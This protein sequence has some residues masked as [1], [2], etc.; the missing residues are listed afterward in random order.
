MTNVKFS[1]KEFEKQ[2]KLTPEV[3]QK[4]SLFGTPLESISDEEIEIEVFPNRPDLISLQGF[5]RGFKAFI[6]KESGMKKYSL[7]KP[8][9][10]Y[11]VKVSKSVSKVRPY[12]VCAVAS[13]LTLD[14]EKI[15]QLV[16]LQE[17]LHTTIGRNRKKVAIGIY[18]LEK[19]SFPIKYEAREPGKISFIPLEYDKEMSATQILNKHPKGKEFANLLKKEEVFPIFIDAKNK[20][21][22]MPPIINS[23]ETGRVTEKT[24]EV[25]IEC[26]GSNFQTLSKTLNI[27]ITTLIEM[28]AQVYQVNLEYPDKKI[29]S[30]D[31]SSEK[32]KISIENANKLLGLSL[33]EKEIEKLFQKMGCDYNNKVVSIP[34]W[35]T[36]ILHEVDLIEDLAIAYGYDKLIPEIPKVSTIAEESPKEK[37]K[38]KVSEILVGLGLTEI[39]SY[40]LI[41]ENEAAISGLKE[42]IELQ[43]SKTEYKILRPNLLIPALRIFS[44]N[45]DNEYPQEIFEIGTVFSLDKDDETETGIKEKENLLVAFSPGNFTK[46]KQ[47]LDYL[48]R[49]FQ[50]Q[51]SLKSFSSR[52]LIEGRTAEIIINGKTQ[53]YFG[54]VHPETLR[55]WTIK[56][57]ISIL[58]ISLEDLTK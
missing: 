45:K 33:K 23:E 20:I 54:E 14:D 28:N 50:F 40:H 46:I 53:G 16:E 21:L 52:E 8:K 27:I 38:T 15:K 56:M 6:G 1:R 36:D 58:E 49:I 12:T 34:A 25:F 3:I 11:V 2:V 30:P 37:F 42:K 22:S 44:E 4:I 57:P 9:E 18:P 19:I 17:K 26:S 29:I 39:V 47:I 51:Y 13:N 24:K 43:D 48:S 7:S 31:L 5:L 55:D 35:R 41:K 32:M 10:N